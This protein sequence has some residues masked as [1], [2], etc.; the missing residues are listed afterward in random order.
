MTEL[1]DKQKTAAHARQDKRYR[2]EAALKQYNERE[3]LRGEIHSREYIHMV[4]AGIVMLFRGNEQI[5]TPSG[6]FITQELDRTRQAGIRAAMDGC[7]KML[8]KTVP[9]LKQIELRADVTQEVLPQ[10]IEYT[11]VRPEM[12]DGD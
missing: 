3:H 2:E 1:T 10:T 5:L 4:H 8:N 12:L 7:F 11:V 6:E 9:D